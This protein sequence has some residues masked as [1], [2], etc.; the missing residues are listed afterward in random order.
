MSAIAAVDMALW[1][2]KGKV[3]GLPLYQLLGGGSR[4]GVMVYGHAN[5][6]D[7]AETLDEVG[8]LHRAGLQGDPR[9]VAA[10][11]GSPR[12]T[13]C[14]RT[15][16]YYEPADAALP[17]RERLVDREVSRPCAE[18]V[19]GGARAL[20][21]RASPAARRAS[22]PDADRGGAAR[23]DRSSPTGCS[24]WRTRRRRRTR[25]LPPDPPA[26]HHAARGRRDLQ[27]DLGLQ[28]ADRRAA[29]RLH[30]RDGRA[31]G[32]HHAPAPHRRISPSSTRCAPAAMARPTCR[33]CAWARRCT[34]TCGCP[35]SAS[36]N[37]CGTRRRPTRC[38][39]TPTRFDD[40][41]LH[42]GEAPGHGVDIDEKLAASYPYKP[43]SLPVDRL[44]D[45]TMWNW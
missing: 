28:D 31:R 22:P 14:R 20:R 38:S 19:R 21:L 27:H 23:Q 35:T 33:R 32:R 16:M 42:P 45:G 25:R 10:C 17:T 26:H 29:D 44:E 6:R 4:D 43:S 18:A 12:P 2:I 37:T 34:S 15:G 7:I 39:R 13:A 24:G 1:D 36:R 8:A 9:A 3:A 41:Y 5:G 40:G 11:R 30:P